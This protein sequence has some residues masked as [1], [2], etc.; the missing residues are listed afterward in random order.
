MTSDEKV[1]REVSN[2]QVEVWKMRRL[3]NSYHI[4]LASLHNEEEHDS[5]GEGGDANEKG[6]HF[7]GFGA[8]HSGLR[9]KCR[10][11]KLKHKQCTP[12][13]DYQFAG[14]AAAPSKVGPY[15]NSDVFGFLFF[16]LKKFQSFES[17]N[18]KPRHTL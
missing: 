6:H 5:A 11:I 7:H 17:N 15:S 2:E 13:I 4:L 8:T 16:F 18:L 12:Q 10:R 1:V 9:R 14:V 3:L